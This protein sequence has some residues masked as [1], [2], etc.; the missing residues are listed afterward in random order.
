MRV[1]V[2]VKTTS[3]LARRADKKMGED[4]RHHLMRLFAEHSAPLVPNDESEY[5]ESRS[6]DYAVATVATPDLELRF[7]R[8]RGEL[9]VDI[10]LPGPHRKVGQARLCFALARYAAWCPNRIGYSELGIWV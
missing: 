8:V 2:I 9:S 6:F 10:S 7:V 4:I 1:L 5:R 3:V